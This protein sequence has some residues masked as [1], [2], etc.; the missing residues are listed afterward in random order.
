METYSSHDRSLQLL[1]NSIHSPLIYSQPAENLATYKMHNV[2][3]ATLKRIIA[4]RGDVA[5]SS[6]LSLQTGGE[7]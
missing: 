4:L 5:L 3:G 2:K 1:H 6:L 7:G